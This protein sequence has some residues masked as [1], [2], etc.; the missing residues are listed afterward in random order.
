MKIIEHIKQFYRLFLS[1]Y[2]FA[3]GLVTYVAKL[4]NSATKSLD[5]SVFLL[6]E[7]RNVV[8]SVCLFLFVN[9]IAPVFMHLSPDI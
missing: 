5:L 7:C 6:C 4:S 9:S 3:Q 8:D 1:S 2:S